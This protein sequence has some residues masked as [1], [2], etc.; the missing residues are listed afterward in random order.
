MT[1]WE[2]IQEYNT[3]TKDSMLVL[4]HWNKWAHVCGK[5]SDN[6]TKEKWNIG[7]LATRHKNVGE[8]FWIWKIIFN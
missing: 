4:V 3:K 2:S 1:I 7:Y 5:I 8:G 6:V